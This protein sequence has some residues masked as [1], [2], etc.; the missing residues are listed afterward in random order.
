M[1]RAYSLRFEALESRE[2]LSTAHAAVAHAARAHA[3]PAAVG[4]PL[5]L[6]GTLTVDNRAA[7]TNQNLDGGYT[8]SAP[9]S[10]QFG[11]LGQV[12]GVW[13][14]S[15]DSY[16]DYQGPDTITLHD[17]QGA[18][19]VEFNDGT[20]GPAHSTGHHTV[21]YQHAQHV[22]SGSGA[23][24]GATESGT[25]DLNMNAKHTAVESMTLSSESM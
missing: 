25:I 7:T 23:Y 16:G 24:A 17:A 5:V 9:V 18:F 20:P 6:D 2:L 11:G 10:G 15:T 22:A 13:Y 12:H 4:A 8:T 1:G 14:E 19:T 21:Y 3:R